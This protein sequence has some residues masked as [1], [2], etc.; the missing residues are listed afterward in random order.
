[1]R[2]LADRWLTRFD[3]TAQEDFSYRFLAGGSSKGLGCP[4]TK[5][6][7]AAYQ[8]AKRPGF[9]SEL[10]GMRNWDFQGSVNRSDG[11]YWGTDTRQLCQVRICLVQFRSA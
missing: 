10:R 7:C 2:L 3:G 4:E 1:M 9:R 11:T 6:E 8:I 5:W